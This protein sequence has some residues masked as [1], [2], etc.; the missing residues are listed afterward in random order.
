MEGMRRVLSYL[1]PYWI[2]LA[3]AVLLILGTA[4]FYVRREARDGIL[5]NAPW[6]LVGI[7]V[8][9]LVTVFVVERVM[10]AAEERRWQPLIQTILWRVRA[11]SMHCIAVLSAKCNP[12]IPRANERYD[13]EGRCARLREAI[14]K[15][16][17]FSHL[18][19]EERQALYHQIEGSANVLQ[20]ELSRHQLV[21]SRHPDLYRAIVQVEGKTLE[22]SAY[23]DADLRPGVTGQEE[24]PIICQV[25]CVFLALDS[26]L[27]KIPPSD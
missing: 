26:E 2:V 18:A 25:A 1:R 27:E 5:S 11:H 20:D 14:E 7:A 3:F 23:R 10:A 6:E 9:A 13:H 24:N 12:D 15:A 17:C 19:S 21:F 16:D 4:I 8:S 22:W